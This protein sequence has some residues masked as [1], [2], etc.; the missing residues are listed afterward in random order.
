MGN[1]EGEWSEYEPHGT[2][3]KTTVYINGAESNK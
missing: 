1:K 3:L 2:V